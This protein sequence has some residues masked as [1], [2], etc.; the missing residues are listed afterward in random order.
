MTNFSLIADIDTENLK[1]QIKLLETDLNNL[2]NKK[3]DLEKLIHEFSVRHNTELGEL[4]VKIWECRKNK[5]KG[6]E[7]EADT[8]EDYNT[9]NKQFEALKEEFITQL[10]EDEQK[11]LKEKY[12]KASK[13][14]HPDVVSEEQKELATKI[15]AELSSAYEKSDLIKVREILNNLE[16]GNFFLSKS[17]TINQK[18]FLEIEI[19]KLRIKVNELNGELQEIK[20]SETYKTIEKIENWDTYFFDAKRNLKAQLDKLESE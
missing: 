19:D 11:E 3:A 8:E 17:D 13:M 18:Q 7:L 2:T 14:C 20:N 6:T 5:A 16:S 15:F 10:T 1:Q 12:R 4:I 9:Y